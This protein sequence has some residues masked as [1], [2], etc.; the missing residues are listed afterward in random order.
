MDPEKVP[1]MEPRSFQEQNKSMS[2][3]SP[4]R[5]ADAGTVR[6]VLLQNIRCGWRA[7]F[8][9]GYSLWAAHRFSLQ[10]VRC[11]RRAAFRCRLFVMGGAPYF[12]AGYSLW[13]AGRVSLQ[14][15]HCGSKVRHSGEVRCSTH[16]HD[17]NP[18][19]PAAAFAEPTFPA[20]AEQALFVQ[21]RQQH[22][23]KCHGRK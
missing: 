11:G 1:D 23:R 9:Q 6:G 14:D 7:A 15:I 4:S 16:A 12:A 5:T 10:D 8:A 2:N 18:Q 13:V 3:N 19:S 21:Q 22:G 20:P 17:S